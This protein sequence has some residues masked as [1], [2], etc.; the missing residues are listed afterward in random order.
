MLKKLVLL[1]GL[2]AL[3]HC[4]L[5]AFTQAVVTAYTYIDIVTMYVYKYSIYYILFYWMPYAVCSS[6][7][8]DLLVTQL[9][10][11]ASALP[12]LT[13]PSDAVAK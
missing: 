4:Q 11:V 1:F 10:A 12:A 5:T 3:A 6:T 7:V 8:I 13:L 9:K 2:L